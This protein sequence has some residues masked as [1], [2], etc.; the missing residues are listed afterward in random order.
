MEF[1]QSEKVGTLLSELKIF[2]KVASQKGSTVH[3]YLNISH[4]LL[5]MVEPGQQTSGDCCNGNERQK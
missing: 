2:E 4:L 5:D 1:C 3:M